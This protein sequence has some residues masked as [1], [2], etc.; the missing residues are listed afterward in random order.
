M[1][2]WLLLRGVVLVACGA[3]AQAPVEWSQPASAVGDSLGA[4]TISA[5]GRSVFE[6]PALA[7]QPPGDSGQC[8]SSVRY[9]RDGSDW[10]ATWNRRRADGTVAVVAARSANQG[11]SW[12]KP[13]IVDSV[14]VARLGCDRPGPA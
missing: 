13:A 4:L 8:A 9:A 6:R 2:M 1:K 11:G 7:P 12:S 3:C 10:Y 14:D 5:D